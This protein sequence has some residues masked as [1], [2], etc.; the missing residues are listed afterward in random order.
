MY[1]SSANVLFALFL[2][3]NTSKYMDKI[4][5]EIAT[6]D[7]LVGYAALQMHECA[8]EE[9]WF[10]ALASLLL[11]TEQVLRW[12]ADSEDRELLSVVISKAYE[13]EIITKDEAQV[14]N[15]MRKYRNR[16]MHS[17]FHGIPF[18]IN[19]LLYWAS[20]AETAEMLYETL[21]GPC[22]LIIRKLTSS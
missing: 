5:S 2:S 18:D 22:L 8:S 14:L 9:K 11:L 4:I 10:P 6:H 1:K 19:G 3:K 17:N 20:E 15:D 13:A 7:R 21:C 16:Y 12:A